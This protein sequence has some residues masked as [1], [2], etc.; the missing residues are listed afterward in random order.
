MSVH[1]PPSIADVPASFTWAASEMTTLRGANVDV[2]QTLNQIRLPR[3]CVC[4]LYLQIEIVRR[5]AGAF[6]QTTN[7][8]LRVGMGRTNIGRNLNFNL[9]P[10][11]TNPLEFTIPFLPMHTLTCDVTFHPS[12]V[13]PT[14]E[15]ILKSSLMAAPFADI[16]QG[17]EGGQPINFDMPVV[18]Q[19]TGE[20]L[21]DVEDQRV[22][23]RQGHGN[24]PLR[25]FKPR[26]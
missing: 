25:R 7:A 16:T 14:D 20:L 2:T 12:T 23:L 1:L 8:T 9:L 22:R 26:S 5:A 17:M 19:A 18:D 4:T 21:P 10:G 13:N 6:I 15:I 24:T 11:F 3:P